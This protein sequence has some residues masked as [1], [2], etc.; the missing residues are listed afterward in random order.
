[1][2]PRGLAVDNVGNI[3]V[4]DNLNH[5]IQV[6]DPEGNFITSFGRLGSSPGCLDTPY[7]VAVNRWGHVIVADSGNHRITCFT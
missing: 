1:M 6:I 5:R 7:A 3:L 4:A 2:N